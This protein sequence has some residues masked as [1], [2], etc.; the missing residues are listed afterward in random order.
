MAEPDFEQLTA[1]LAAEETSLRER[2]RSLEDDL[3]RLLRGGGHANAEHADSAERE[4]RKIVLRLVAIERE[5][6]ELRIAAS[7]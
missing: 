6:T 4:I 2:L 7:R 3:Q 5:Q 1:A